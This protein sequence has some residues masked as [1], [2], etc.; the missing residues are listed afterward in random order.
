M[1]QM[2]CFS[3]SSC[4]FDLFHIMCSAHTFPPLLFCVFFPYPPFVSFFLLYLS[5]HPSS[6]ASEVSSTCS[7]CPVLHQFTACITLPAWRLCADGCEVI[8]WCQVSSSCLQGWA[9]IWP[10]VI[11][12]GSRTVGWLRVWR[13]MDLFPYFFSSFL[14]L[15]PS[16]LETTHCRTSCLLLCPWG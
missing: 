9:S 4:S 14:S 11:P 13:L 8:S 7:K 1:S 6:W 16:P 5:P 15:S 12:Q 3:A 10:P 2:G